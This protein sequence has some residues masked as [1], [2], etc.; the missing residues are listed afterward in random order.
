MADLKVIELFSGIGAQTQALKNL[1]IKHTS[2][3]CEFNKKIHSI[4]E[5]IHGQTPNLGDIT[6]IENI[7]DCDLLTYSFPC[8]DLSIL[9]NQEGLQKGSGTRSS[10]LWEVER[11]LINKHK[12]HS[13]PKTLLLENVKQLVSKKNIDQ[14][15]EWLNFLSSIGYKNSWKILDS[16]NYGVPQHRERVFVVS[17]LD[18]SFVFNDHSKYH[19]DLC[20]FMDN[21]HDIVNEFGDSLYF[22]NE[23]MREKIIKTINNTQSTNSTNRIYGKKSN[24]HALT[25]CGSH[26]GNFGAVLYSDQVNSTFPLRLALK[27]LSEGSIM[28]THIGFDINTVRLASP[29]EVFRL[30]GFDMVSYANVKKYFISNK[31]SMT[32]FYHVSGNS[33]VVPVLEDIFGKLYC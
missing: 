12:T 14:F 26:P 29:R 8:Q 3:C 5:A 27:G 7:P 15:N 2:I 10:L 6:K 22:K 31:I 9:G 4:Y 23:N 32:N 1:K 28:S 24:I 20:T 17:S 13:L 11:L 33:I 18:D 16:A 21:D 19:I 25:T 30:M